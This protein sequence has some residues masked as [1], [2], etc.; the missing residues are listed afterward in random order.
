[1][2]TINIATD[3]SDV[4]G[5]RFTTDG[6]FNGEDFRDK[7]LAPALRIHG[8]AIVIFDG[9]E[10]FGSSFLEEAF[11]GLVRKYD[12]DEP[13]LTNHLQLVA[14]SSSAKRYKR[15]ALKFIENA[16]QKRKID[17]RSKAPRGH[18]PNS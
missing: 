15:L 2:K 11:G 5:G 7:L 14:D 6:P 16:M 3:F 1:M 18:I 8:G 17:P 9:T 10:G 13:F 4:P 12:F